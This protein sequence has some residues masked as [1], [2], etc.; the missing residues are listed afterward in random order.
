MI[1][2]ATRGPTVT[3]SNSEAE[4]MEEQIG[5]MQ[6]PKQKRFKYLTTVIAKKKQLLGTPK[7]GSDKL[8]RKYQDTK[9]S[10]MNWRKQMIPWTT[11]YPWNAN[12][13][14]YHSWYMTSCQFL[15]LLPLL[16]GSS[17]QVGILAWEKE[18]A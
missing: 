2:N 11:G 9:Q 10:C 14:L 6:E 15:H 4:Q 13:H 3:S 1:V 12:F 5:E 17:Q 18:T 16:N 8:M 7:A